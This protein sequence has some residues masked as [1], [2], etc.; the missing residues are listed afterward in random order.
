VLAQEH[1]RGPRVTGERVTRERV[2]GERG[3]YEKW[4]EKRVVRDKRWREAF[5]GVTWTDV[6]LGTMLE[7]STLHVGRGWRFST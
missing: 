5:S 4:Y 7:P 2:I 1:L 3:W 6:T